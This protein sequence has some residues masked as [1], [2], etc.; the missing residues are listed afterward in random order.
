[1]TGREGLVTTSR[2]RATKQHATVRGQ[3]VAHVPLGQWG[4]QKHSLRVRPVAL[5]LVSGGNLRNHGCVTNRVKLDSWVWVGVCR[6]RWYG[7]GSNIPC[8]TSPRVLFFAASKKNGLLFVDIKLGI[9]LSGYKDVGLIGVTKV[10]VSDATNDSKDLGLASI[11]RSCLPLCAA[12]LGGPTAAATLL[13]LNTRDP[14]GL[15]ET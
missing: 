7:H 14:T 1:M 10:P 9:I 5:L 8:W 11:S 12:S 4:R 2:V 6:R 3:S 15:L 13:L